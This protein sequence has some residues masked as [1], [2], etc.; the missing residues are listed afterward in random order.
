MDSQ[1]PQSFSLVDLNLLV[2]TKNVVK[3]FFLLLN[4]YNYTKAEKCAI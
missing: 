2:Q 4:K 1:G 3:T